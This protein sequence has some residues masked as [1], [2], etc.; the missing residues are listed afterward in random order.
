LEALYQQYKGQAEFLSVYVREAHPVEG[1]RMES[2]DKAGVV[3]KQP[4][5]NKERAD[6]AKSC[7]AALEMSMPLLVDEIDDRAGHAYSGMPDRLYVIGSDGRVAYKGG[8]GPFGFIPGEMEQ[9]LVMLLLDEAKN[10]LRTRVPLMDEREAHPGS[11]GSPVR[12]VQ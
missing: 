9:S 7:C 10:K 11:C 4:R 2:N 3:V 8:R 12:G 5:S 6:V 1:W